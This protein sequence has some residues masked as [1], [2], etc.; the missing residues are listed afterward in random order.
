MPSDRFLPQIINYSY[1][2]KFLRLILLAP[3]ANVI[4]EPLPWLV[5]NNRSSKTC[6]AL[7]GVRVV[8]C[9]T[10]FCHKSK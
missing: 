3:A 8:V 6:L 2:F 10:V 9:S 5:L 1:A 7:Q 4:S